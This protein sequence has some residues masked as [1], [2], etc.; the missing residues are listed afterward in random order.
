M[1]NIEGKTEKHRMKIIGAFL[2]LIISISSSSQDSSTLDSLK[3]QLSIASS[4]TAKILLRSEI[5]FEEWI[6][7]E[8]YWDSIAVDCR[9]FLKHSKQHHSSEVLVFKGRLAV[10]LMSIAYVKTNSGYADDAIKLYQETLII[11]KELDDKEAI[12]TI[13]NN[14]A[15][16]YDYKG[17]IPKALELY[18]NSMEI[19]L[20]IGDSSGV[21]ATLN[22]LAYLYANLEEYDMAIENFTKSLEMSKELEDERYVSLALNNL[23]YV[24]QKQGDLVKSEKYHQESLALRIKSNDLKGIA[25]SNNMLGMV[26][27]EN[28]EYNKALEFFK[29]SLKIYSDN[30]SVKGVGTT[31]SNMGK[32]FILKGNYEEADKYIQQSLD[33]ATELGYPLDI[34]IAAEMLTEI[35]KQKGDWKKA[36]EMFELSI[37]M[38]DSLKNIEN[39]KLVIKQNLQNEYEKM[40]LADS[41]LT[42]EEKKVTDAEIGTHKA[43]INQEQTKRY[44]L[45]GGLAI[46]IL[47]GVFMFNRFL[48]SQKQ[49]TL[50]QE[51]KDI[52]QEKNK[53]ILDSINYAKR[54]QSAIL[55]DPAAINANLKDYFILYKP[56]D[57]VAGDFYWLEI[58]NGKTLF[59]VADC[60]GHGV[61]GAM[62]SVVCNNGLNRSVREHALTDPGK[63]LDKTRE[64]VIQ[65]FSKSGEEEMADGMDISLCSIEGNK[66]QWA[67]ANNPLWIIRKGELLETLPNRQPIGKYPSPKPFLTHE[68]TLE[69]EDRLYLFS[70]GFADQ[71]G[72]LKGKKYKVKNLKKLLISISKTPMNEQQG[73][74]N[75]VFEKWR[76]NLVQIDDICIL[77]LKI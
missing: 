60:T 1:I 69:K 66:L 31:L 20:E 9:S 10:A 75:T 14:L 46:V 50:I 67:G 8:G 4:D 77:G 19:R 30:N 52:V 74:L 45:Y 18:Q 42:A 48:V 22:N 21:A 73:M 70:D 56:K 7:R 25:M 3:H 59:A 37:L 72:G 16:I 55:P 68:I 71:F 54:I 43:Q 26:A 17:D 33:I 40:T 44:T 76:A 28:L 13:L 24:Y 12:A 27:K 11:Q 41:L 57:I 62:I 2:I 38:K 35:N 23:G 49:N 32:T 58:K 29:V 36:I 53:E 51:Q 39:N 15:N 63:I 5:G 6:I 64:I 61:P 34:Q 65:E 47:F